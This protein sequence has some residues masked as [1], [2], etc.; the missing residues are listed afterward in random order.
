MFCERKLQTYQID[1]HPVFFFKMAQLKSE[2]KLITTKNIA[3]KLSTLKM[4]KRIAHYCNSDKFKETG[5][6]T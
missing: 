3:I 2:H 4:R 5:N 6:K 1:V